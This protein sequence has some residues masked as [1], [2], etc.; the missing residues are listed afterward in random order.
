MMQSF[1]A[2]YEVL[3]VVIYTAHVSTIEIDACKCI[4]KGRKGTISTD[5]YWLHAPKCHNAQKCKLHI[6]GAATRRVNEA[7][8]HS[9]THSQLVICKQKIMFGFIHGY[10]NKLSV[11]AEITM[12]VVDLEI[13]NNMR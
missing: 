4:L 2:L 11:P 9:I 1:E 7:E 3:P 12:N 10:K 13:C 6:A 5:N 8:R